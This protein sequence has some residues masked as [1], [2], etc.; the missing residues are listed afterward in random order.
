MKARMSASSLESSPA[1][2]RALGQSASAR[3]RLLGA[4][5]QRIEAEGL[6]AVSLDQIRREAG[7]SVGALYHHFADKTALLD[8]LFLELTEDFQAGFLADLRSHAAA[9]AGIE[10]GVRFYLGWVHR[11]RT[12]ARILLAHRPEG[13]ALRDR[14]REFF[15]E[16]MSWWQTHVYYGALRALPFDLIHALWLGPA[17]EYTRHW[18]IGRAKR[19]PP[20]VAD[21][22][23]Q[24]AWNALKEPS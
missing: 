18:L 17:H 8:A 6:V 3:E 9:D 1:A 19:T 11:H 2:Q 13:T 7:V 16:V 10:A 5:L 22:L 15:A 14:N 12:G 20:A 4:A 23:S 24:A 21:T